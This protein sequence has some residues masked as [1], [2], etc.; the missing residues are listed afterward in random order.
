MRDC[1]VLLE[2]R[3]GI[4]VSPHLHFLGHFTV[5]AAA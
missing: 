5:T 1:G 4:G 3:A 2:C